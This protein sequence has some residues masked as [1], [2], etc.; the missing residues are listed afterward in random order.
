LPHSPWRFYETGEPYDAVPARGAYP[1]TA[2]NDEGDW[3]AAV[4]EQRHLLQAQYTDQI[5]GDLLDELQ[6]RDLYEESLVI[7]V[8]DHGITFDLDVPARSLAEGS[9]DGIGGLAYSPLFIKPPG[10]TE[11]TID[12]ANIQSVDVLPT[13]ADILDI[14]VPFEVEGHAAGSKGIEEQGDEKIFYD[15]IGPIGNKTLRGVVEFPDEYLPA[16]ADRWIAPIGPDDDPMSGLYEAFGLDDLIGE[17]L[18]AMITDQGG[19][20]TI[21]TLG[22]LQATADGAVPIGAVLGRVAVPT[23]AEGVVVAAV[24]DRI[25]AASPLHEFGG[26][27]RSFT[28]LFPPDVVGTGE[29]RMALVSGETVTELSLT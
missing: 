2:H 7:V 10:Q 4:T 23:T 5:V 15:L 18:D 9:L 25:V 13:I 27:A 26:E 6:T 16:A 29:V 11:G 8:A 3:V 12:D 22:Q 17:P 24:D 28:L 1:F 21:P 20:A 14:D 19:V